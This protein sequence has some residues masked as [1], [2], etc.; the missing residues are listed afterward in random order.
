[1]GEEET[2]IVDIHFTFWNKS[3][4]KLL[5]KRANALRKVKFEKVKKIEA[6]MDRLKESKF[7]QLRTPNT[8]YCTFENSKASS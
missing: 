6:E 7:D 2:R 1:M 5:M 3:M 4:L 8:F